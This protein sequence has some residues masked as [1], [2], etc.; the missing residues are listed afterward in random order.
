[1]S[2]GSG[3]LLRAKKC[4][5]CEGG[6]EACSLEEARKLMEQ[7]NQ[8]TLSEDGKRISKTWKLKNF[9]IGLEKIN[10]IGQLAEEEAHHP[11]LHLESYRMLR[12]EIW[13]HAIGG[14]SEND[15]ILAA[16]IDAIMN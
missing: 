12:V 2:T 11:D 13:T 10:A 1:M 15:F 8:W 4:V 9:V 14:L 16:K 3:D 7:L 6:V 5:P